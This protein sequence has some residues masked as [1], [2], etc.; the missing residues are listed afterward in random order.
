[1]AAGSGCVCV[2]VIPARYHSTR[3]PGK[4]LVPIDGLPMVAHV[5]RRAASSRLDSV[6]VATDHPAVEDAMSDLDIPVMMTSSSHHSGTE[7]VAEVAKRTGGDV[8]I[9][10]QGDEPTIEPA[11]IDLLISEFE[12]EPAPR[13]ATV[14]STHLSDE[15]WHDSN[16]VKVAVGMD[17][18]AVDFFREPLDHQ[19]RNSCYKHLGIYGFTRDFLLEFA[20]LDRSPNEEARNLEQMRALDNGVP[21]S[22]AITG[23]DSVGINTERDLKKL[24]E[25]ATI[26]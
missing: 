6:L 23:L 24:K 25:T 22:V 13:M 3:F 20:A 19:E 7:R 1:M 8:F 12:K 10:I 17:G 14:G 2:G 4:V 15:H 16:V 5:Y 9:N 21:I 26:A 11:I 18:R